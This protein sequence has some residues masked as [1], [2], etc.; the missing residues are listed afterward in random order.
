VIRLDGNCATLSGEEVTLKR[1]PAPK[2]PQVP[3]RR[4]DPRTRTALL[5]DPAIA[6]ASRFDD[7]CA[8]PSPPACAKAE[9]KLTAAILDFMAHGGKIPITPTGR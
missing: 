2:H 1:P 7:E 9:S 4:L 8:D 3:W 5:A 6:D